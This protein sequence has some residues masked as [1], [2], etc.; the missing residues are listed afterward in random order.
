VTGPGKGPGTGP[1]TVLDAV[2]DRYDVVIA[3]S[4]A[5]GAA[6]ALLLARAGL[7]VLVVDPVPPDR[8]ALST[9]ALMRGAVLQLHRWGV[10]DDIRAAGTP[11]VRTTVFH[12][13]DD[14]IRVPIKPADGVDALYAPRRTV[15]DPALRRAAVEAGARIV[16]GA[17]VT[18][19]LRGPDGRVVGAEISA[20]KGGSRTV[21]AERVIGADG[22]NSRVA[23]LVD[24]PVDHASRYAAATVYGYW[25][26]PYPGEYHWMYES[27]IGAGSISTNDGHACVFL[28]VPS[29]AFP[30]LRGQ[31][32]DVMLQEGLA[33]LAPEL[34]DRVAAGPP[35]GRLHAFAG[36]RGFLRRSWGPGWA[37]VGD[38]G[39]FKDPVTAHGITDAL[40]DAELLA[41]AILGGTDT[42]LRRYQATRDEVVHALMG[43]TDR[44]ASFE[45]DLDEVRSLHLRLS[46]EM[47]I[48][49]EL[50]RTFDAPRQGGRAPVVP[51]AA[52]P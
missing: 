35:A 39:C 30:G 34:A 28:A 40:R 15:L 26:D 46:K 10:L 44:I 13:G 4:R 29:A 42:A 27:G 50:M 2:R 12:Y 49:V 19:L 31:G 18:D 45:W 38:A 21:R 3:G 1:G 22:V 52:T 41:R 24:A 51:V 33:R 8:D 20:G 5:A 32:L 47:N 7:Q 6:T 25:P 9:H 11:P 48:G 36:V 43:T 23:R 17:S 37:L 14:A 16:H